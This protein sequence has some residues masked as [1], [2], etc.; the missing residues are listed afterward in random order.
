MLKYV[1]TQVGFR[2]VPDKIALLVNISGCKCHC[3]GCHSKY[4]W[5]DIGDPLTIQ[6]LDKLIEDND[7]INCVCF[8]GGEDFEAISE[9]A[10]FVHS[11]H[12]L[13]VAWYTGHDLADVDLRYVSSVDFLKVGPYRDDCGP[14]DKETTNQRMYSISHVKGLEWKDGKL[15]QRIPKL[16]DITY[17]FWTRQ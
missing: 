17:R 10:Q 14:L 16:T 13:L 9:L 15:T 5:E 7:G 8:M 3:P 6:S 12:D 4:L 11:K 2:E 1:N